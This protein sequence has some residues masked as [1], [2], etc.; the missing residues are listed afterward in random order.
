MCKMYAQSNENGENEQN[1]MRLPHPNFY[2]TKGTSFCDHEFVS[3]FS[4]RSD[5]KCAKKR[6]AK[7]VRDNKVLHFGFAWA[8]PRKG[9]GSHL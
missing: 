4:A 7:T 3:K 5:K 6:V 2:F 8:T 1:A 9:H